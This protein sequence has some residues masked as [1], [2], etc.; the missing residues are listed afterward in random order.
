MEGFQHFGEV[1]IDA[2]S[3]AMTVR[4]RDQDNTVLWSTTLAAAAQRTVATGD[5]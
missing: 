2:H 1:D 3:R 5:R 4:L